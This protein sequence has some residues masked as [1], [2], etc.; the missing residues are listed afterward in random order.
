M[1]KLNS[2][3][4]I[5][6]SVMITFFGCQENDYQF[7]E[8]LTPSSIAVTAEI[9]GKDASNPYGDGSGE[10][11]GNCRN[12]RQAAQRS[13]HYPLTVRNRA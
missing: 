10:R 13:L 1:K 12:P 9:V 3:L 4:I 5:V 8:I 6:F 2:I 11:V 7:G